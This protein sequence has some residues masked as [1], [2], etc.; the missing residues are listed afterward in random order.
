MEH[1]RL[2][3]SISWMKGNDLVLIRGT[4]QELMKTCKDRNLRAEV[5][6]QDLQSTE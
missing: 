3:P 4:V 5:V 2:V 6:T 1:V